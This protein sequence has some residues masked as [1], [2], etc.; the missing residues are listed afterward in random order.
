MKYLDFIKIAESNSY[1]VTNYDDFITASKPHF[2]EITIFKTKEKEVFINN[3]LCELG[4]FEVIEASIKLANTRLE[5]RGN[6]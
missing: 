3:I 5:D 1:K 2:N 6:K 4:D